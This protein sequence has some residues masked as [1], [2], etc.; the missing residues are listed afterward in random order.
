MHKTL[1]GI[2]AAGILIAIS[3]A[4]ASAAPLRQDTGIHKQVAGEEFSSQRRYRRSYAPVTMGRAF[5]T[6]TPATPIR[7]TAT[8]MD[9]GIRTTPRGRSSGSARSASGSVT[10]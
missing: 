9:T 6:G 10:G 7:I 2:A 3:G 8:G 1:A 5:I 4:T